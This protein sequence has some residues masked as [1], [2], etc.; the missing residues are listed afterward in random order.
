MKQEKANGTANML[1]ASSQEEAKVQ[2]NLMSCTMR[3]TIPNN[4]LFSLAKEQLLQGYNVEIYTKGNSM[5][6]FIE[7]GRD[8]VVL[9]PFKRLDIGDAVLAEIRTG[10]FVL[11][12]II[13]LLP[14]YAVLQG[15]GNLKGEEICSKKK[16]YGVLVEYIRPN[17]M[18]HANDYCLRKKIRIWYHLRP[19]RRILLWIYKHYSL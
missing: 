10:K 16:I 18:L 17:K 7:G 15:D 12:R 5:R 6:P 4:A 2:K 1:L 8:K 19:V 14:G 11:H 13:D 3:K 9:A